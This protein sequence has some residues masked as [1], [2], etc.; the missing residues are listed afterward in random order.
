MNHE[1]SLAGGL[2]ANG[3]RTLPWVLAAI[4]LLLV[5]ESG[6]RVAMSGWDSGRPVVE[7]RF[8]GWEP[9]PQKDASGPIQEVEFLMAH[10]RPEIASR[11]LL[12]ALDRHPSNLYLAVRLEEVL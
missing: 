1:R 3:R 10:R 9:K 5:R 7:L 4:V 2:W 8:P 12:S 6:V 11:V